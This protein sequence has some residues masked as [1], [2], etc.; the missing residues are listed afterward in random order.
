MPAL[1]VFAD[2]YA[3]SWPA[4]ERGDAPQSL[5]IVDA[6][7]R[8]FA[9]DAHLVAYSLPED[10][11]RRRLHSDALELLT[12]PPLMV[13]LVVDVDPAGH[14]ATNRWRED[15]R[16][17]AGYLLGDPFGYFTRGGARFVWRIDPHAITDAD[18]WARWYLLALIAIAA[19]S[20]IVADPACCDWTRMYRL[21]HATRDGEP[22]RHGWVCGSPDTI[23]TWTA[24]NM[25]PADTLA[26]LG[27]LA[28]QS[29]AWTRRAVRLAPPAPRPMRAINATGDGS[30][31]LRWAVSQVA[32]HGKGDR[33][34]E[35]FR[36]TRWLAGLVQ[37]GELAAADV[38]RAMVDAGIAAGL[39]VAEVRRTVRSALKGAA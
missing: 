22:Q 19:M 38:D 17:R 31:A 15:T 32:A 23:G 36:R 27:W 2:K 39:R 30:R 4:H 11:P 28:A 13:L 29:T 9:T 5:E 3:R 37:R 10:A 16:T 14:V 25:S 35:L 12:A 24:P 8:E 18:A 1:L 34:T 6:F 7:T 33:N 26:T 20:G 21:P